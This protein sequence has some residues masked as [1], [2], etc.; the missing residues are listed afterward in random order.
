MGKNKEMILHIDTGK[1]WRGGQQQAF[2]LHQYLCQNNYK[3]MMVCKK[4]SAM[5]KKCSENDLHIYL[6]PLSS[7]FDIYSAYKIAQFAKKNLMKILHLHTAH[8]LSIGLWAK[9]F[10]KSLRLIA[11]RRVDFSIKSG[12]FSYLK[13]NNNLL[14]ILVCISK[15]IYN[16]ALKDSIPQNKLKIIHSGI[17][18]KKVWSGEFGVGSEFWNNIIKEKYDIPKTNII[19]GTIA[20][21]A[22]HKDYPTLLRASKIVIDKYKNVS[23][24]SIGG[25][26]ITEE[27]KKLHT[28]LYLK[29]HFIMEGH[30]NEIRPYLQSFDIFV[31]SSKLEGLGTS[32]LDAMAA[33]KPIVA[34]NSGGIPEMIQHNINGLLAEKENL[35]DLAEKIMQ[36]IDD[37]DLRMRLAA[38]AKIDVEEFSIEKTIQKNIE[39]YKL[40]IDG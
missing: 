40:M 3:S 34:C 38:Q 7:E 15:N 23:F 25:G 1:T 35:T 18:T 9:L 24:I 31:L 6:L 37:P 4:N 12:I 30:Q 10:Y 22:D 5:E 21:Y 36:L 8:A 13:Y 19:I 14:D 33:R 39:L 20:A 11:V 32:I 17:D 29:N 28:D 26:K 2:Y 16:V 27:L